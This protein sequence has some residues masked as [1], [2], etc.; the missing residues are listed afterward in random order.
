MGGGGRERC[1][2]EGPGERNWCG[3]GGGRWE[4]GV[5]LRGLGKGVGQGVEGGESFMS[6]I[7]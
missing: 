5:Y 1:V 7:G 3:G 2:S 4:K 6:L